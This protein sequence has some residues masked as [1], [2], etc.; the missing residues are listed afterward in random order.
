MTSPQLKVIF[1][2]QHFCVI[3]KPAEWL[4]V[5]SRMGAADPRPV[6]GKILEDQLNAR[7]WPCHR[8]DEDVSGI[9]MFALNAESHKTASTWFETHSVIKTYH[10]LSVATSPLPKPLELQTWTCR[11]MRG[12]RRAYEAPFG[13][14]SITKAKLLKLTSH[15]FPLASLWSLQ[16]QTGR[17]H[18]LRYEMTRHGYPI[19]GDTLYASQHEFNE[20]GIA[21]RAVQLDFTNCAKRE[22]FG[23]PEKITVSDDMSLT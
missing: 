4:S 1:Q 16:P 9:L 14:E 20:K 5:P 12:K 10:A 18:Q 2:N 23:L 7:L 6:A 15:T 8:L 3:Y 11:L 22:M 19:V 17:P 13:K 21:L